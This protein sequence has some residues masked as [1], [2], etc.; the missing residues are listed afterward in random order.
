[1]AGHHRFRFEQRKGRESLIQIVAKRNWVLLED[2]RR[3]QSVRA[4]EDAVKPHA[5]LGRRMS[6]KAHDLHRERADFDLAGSKFSADSA[7]LS[8]RELPQKVRM[9]GSTTV[10]ENGLEKGLLHD[11]SLQDRSEKGKAAFF[12]KVG[13]AEVVGVGVREDRAAGP[14]P[15]FLGPP[16]K[17][18][19]RSIVQ[20][21]VDEK[22]LAFGDQGTE[23]HGT[24]KGHH[25]FS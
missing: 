2:G 1:M 11:R 23:V 13:A 5:D 19:R 12:P 8:E 4:K 22:H 17:F 7:R 25:P 15:L 10:E 24:G 3:E 18:P 21:R 9:G 20:T 16:P 14:K 6:R